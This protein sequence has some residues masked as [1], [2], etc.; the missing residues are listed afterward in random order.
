VETRIAE[1]NLNRT[2]SGWVPP[3]DRVDLFPNSPE[4]MVI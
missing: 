1:E 4:H 2:L 3:E